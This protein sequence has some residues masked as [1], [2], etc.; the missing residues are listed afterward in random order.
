MRKDSTIQLGAPRAMDVFVAYDHREA[1][2]RAKQLCE[3]LCRETNTSVRLKLWHFKDIAAN[4]IQADAPTD[5]RGTR[6]F[7]IA[8]V[9]P[10]GLPAH[11]LNWLKEWAQLNASTNS[12]LAALPLA[13][14]PDTPVDCPTLALLQR[15]ASEN[16]LSF[17]DSRSRD[18]VQ[19]LDDFCDELRLREQTM[20]P[21]LEHI[22]ANTHFEP[23]VHWGIND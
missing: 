9:H 7:L 15:I 4:S 1:A 17:V 22:L 20:T 19:L 11:I 23:H 3:R 10:E 2:A 14:A 21:T 12:I 18:L 16:K 13:L 5:P 8:W 6:V